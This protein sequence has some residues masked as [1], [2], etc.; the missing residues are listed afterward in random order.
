MSR[1]S[2]IAAFTLG[3]CLF[4]GIGGALAYLGYCK[5]GLLHPEIIEQEYLGPPSYI[6]VGAALYDKFSRPLFGC[7]AL[8]LGLIL[9]A[10]FRGPP[11]D[12]S[13]RPPAEPID[14]LAD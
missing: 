6:P 8:G 12:P 2:R 9:L 1:T 10:I 7:V 5:Y 14:P 11:E 13:K 3:L 4:L